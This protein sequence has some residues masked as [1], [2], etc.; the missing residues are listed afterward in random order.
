MSSDEWA[1]IYLM[2]REEYLSGLP[3]PADSAQLL[4]ENGLSIEE[5]ES[6][7]AARAARIETFRRHGVEELIRRSQELFDYG[8]KVLAIM[9]L[10]RKA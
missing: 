8:E 3:D 9:R 10:N 5:Y 2:A 1:K 6:L 7:Q 4:I